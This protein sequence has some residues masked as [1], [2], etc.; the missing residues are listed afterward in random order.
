VEL[1]GRFLYEFLLPMKKWARSFMIFYCFVPGSCI[2][3]HEA[4][5]WPGNTG[6][7]TSLNTQVF[8]L[9]VVEGV[10]HA[11]WSITDYQVVHGLG[12]LTDSAEAPESNHMHLR[13]ATSLTITIRSVFPG[14]ASTFNCDCQRLLVLAWHKISYKNMYTSIYSFRW[15]NGL[16]IL[17]QVVQC[18]SVGVGRFHA[19]PLQL[20]SSKFERS[21]VCQC[22]P[23]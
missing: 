12:L 14:K 8:V 13:T 23:G 19:L 21:R 4:E 9:I 7:M 10:L 6:S 3:L 20:S 11:R 5:V 17:S 15:G 22:W 16:S 1:G 2:A 18:Q